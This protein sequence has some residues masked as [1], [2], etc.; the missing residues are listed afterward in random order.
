MPYV[1]AAEM[2]VPTHHEMR[3]V[4]CKFVLSLQETYLQVVYEIIFCTFSQNVVK[5][6]NT[7]RQIESLF[8]DSYS[9]GQE[10]VRFHEEV[11]LPDRGGDLNTFFMLPFI[12]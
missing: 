8:L 12:Y 10:V 1:T 5:S 3:I 11:V 7:V 4:A 9:E 2:D 6:I